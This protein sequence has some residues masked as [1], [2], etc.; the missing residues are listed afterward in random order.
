MTLTVAHEYGDDLRT[1]REL[2][3]EANRALF[4]GESG[5]RLARAIGMRH[6]VVALEPTYGEHGWHP[7]IHA[8]I[9][10]SRK[11]EPGAVEMLKER[12]QAIVTRLAWRARP[13]LERGA[14]LRPSN[15]ADYIAKLGL[16]VTNIQGKRGR[17]RSLTHWEILAAAIEGD[18]EARRLWLEFSEAMH[19]AKQLT[20]SKGARVALGLNA[21]DED[22]EHAAEPPAMLVA[23]VPGEVWDRCSRRPGWTA[24]LLRRARGS[25]PFLDCAE[26]IRR[27]QAPP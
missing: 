6:R 26:W 22:T 10:H 5:K 1:M 9:F 24:E 14:D 25:T 4:R 8:L 23:S 17:K 7:H 12:W 15:R 27:S 13:S 11:P 16:E 21:R 19:G 18:T 2:V 3:R 20:W